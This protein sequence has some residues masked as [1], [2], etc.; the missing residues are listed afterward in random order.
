M[1]L[2]TIS[3]IHE[4]KCKPEENILVEGSLDESSIYFIETGSVDIFLT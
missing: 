4:Y 1:I 3:L 2:K